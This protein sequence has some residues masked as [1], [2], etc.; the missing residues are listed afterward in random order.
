MKNATR[1]ID[2]MYANLCRLEEKEVNTGNEGV[3]RGFGG[4][5]EIMREDFWREMENSENPFETICFFISKG[6]LKNI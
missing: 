5:H 2:E 1:D 3:D 4:E 6:Y